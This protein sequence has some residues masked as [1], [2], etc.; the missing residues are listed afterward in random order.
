MGLRAS[1]TSARIHP[2][3]EANARILPLALRLL[4]FAPISL[5]GNEVGLLLRYPE[6]GSALLFPPYA[7]LTAALVMSPRRDWVWYIGVSAVTH[8]IPNWGHWSLSWI[9]LA[10]LANVTRAVVAAGMLRWSFGGPP[11]LEGIRA[12]L[13]FVVSTV[14]VAPA[15]GATI[16]AANVVLHDGSPTYWRPWSAWFMSNALT[17]LTMLPLCV[18]A[19][20][21]GAKL[22]RIDMRRGIEAGLLVTALACTCVVALLSRGNGEWTLVLPLYAPLPILIWAALRFGLGGASLALTAVV[23]VAIWGV[24]RNI[25]RFLALSLDDNVL[26]LQL[27]VV[28]TTLPVLCIAAVASAR[29]RAV[30]LFGALLASLQDQ[31][32]IL[33]ARGV[34][35]EVNDSWRVAAR[36]DG[37]QIHQLDAGDDYL[38]VCRVG[39]EQKDITAQRALEGVMS[40][41]ART[42]RRFEMEYEHNNNGQQEWYF[43]TIE[44]LERLDGG[45]VV[46]RT[47]VT[48]RR[49]AEMEI[50]EQRLELLH[51]ARVAL[52]GQFSGA[53]A[54]ELNQPLTAILSN[55]QAAQHLLLREPVNHQELSLI[56]HDIVAEDR[57]AGHVIHRLRSLLRRGE[58]HLETLD[59]SELVPEVLELAHGELIARRVTATSLVEPNL[60]LVLGD[61][62]QL[63]QVLLNLI[64]NACDAMTTTAVSERN[65]QLRVRSDATSHVLFSIRDSGPGIAPALVDRLFEPFVT[66]KPEGLGLGLSISRTIVA[67]HGGRLWAE[68]NADRGAT[69]YCR[70]T[71]S[72]SFSGFGPS[73]MV[74]GAP[75][76]V[77]SARDT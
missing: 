29:Q 41:L 54:H 49:R 8:T 19:L 72:K 13:L 70:L 21:S 2:S 62:V 24:D 22:R 26:A 48:A 77:K 50:A 39:A 75:V 44:A 45:A 66:N 65:L 15:V 4:L 76:S 60:P 32:A 56:L 16:G 6:I 20:T 3:V 33:D 30:R 52:L 64:H 31:V 71:S 51:L 58:T 14:V 61:R 18:I 17:G 37:P 47:N 27:F 53:L 63:Q 5:L 11:Q 34:V 36:S 7:L 23:L 28:L 68:N 46:T 38:R 40:V 9:L 25:G 35:L 55:A 42:L 59:V 12:L 57:R 67:A 73:V 1:R 10:D 43:M 69:L 74:G